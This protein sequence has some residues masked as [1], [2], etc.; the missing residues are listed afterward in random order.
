VLPAA[1]LP[2]E[3]K[4]LAFWLIVTRHSPQSAA[5]SDFAVWATF[6]FPLINLG[7]LAK[8]LHEVIV[9]T[10]LR[11]PSYDRVRFIGR[12][13]NCLCMMGFGLR[14]ALAPSSA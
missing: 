2:G 4:D 3:S 9:T 5:E 8:A 12:Q 11:M 7:I 14:H 1:G 10:I 6:V 13:F